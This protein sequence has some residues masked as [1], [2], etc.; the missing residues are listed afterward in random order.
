MDEPAE[1][2]FE[3]SRASARRAQW[4]LNIL[5]VMSA[6]AASAFFLYVLNTIN[7]FGERPAPEVNV[8]TSA[9]GLKYALLRSDAES[10]L[11]LE[12]RDIDEA[13]SYR[14]A[15]GEQLRAS[16]AIT[17]AGRLFR[18]RVRNA[19]KEPVRIDAP[20]VSVRDKNGKDW[21]VRWLHEV[22]DSGKATPQGRLI[23][24]QSSRDFALGAGESRQMYVFIAGAV[25]PAEDFSSAEFRAEP[26]IKVAM[27]RQEV[28]VTPQ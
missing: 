25:P 23:L 24:G 6:V 26:A 11:S 20:Q 3:R 2:P 7:P 17:E 12:L 19:G 21:Q 1:S 16:L 14:D 8:P 4:T 9:V 27:D 28:K 13:P 10:A 18:L 15:L 5:V 22:A